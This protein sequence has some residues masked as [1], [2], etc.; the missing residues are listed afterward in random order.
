M[1]NSKNPAQ[2]APPGS[3][4]AAEPSFAIYIALWIAWAIGF[5]LT[6]FLILSTRGDNLPPG[7]G[8][9]QGCGIVLKSEYSRVLDISLTTWSAGYFLVAG[10]ILFM[11]RFS[12]QISLAPPLSMLLPVTSAVGVAAGI[13]SIVIMGTVLGEFCYYCVALH[14]VNLLFFILSLLYASQDWCH[15]QYRRWKAN[16]PTLPFSPI[17]LHVVLALLFIGGQTALMSLAHSGPP[18][19]LVEI[20]LKT[21]L[22]VKSIDD[23]LDVMALERVPDGGEIVWT[24]KGPRDAPYKIVT[25]TCPTCPHCKSAND[26]LKAIMAQ[27]PGQL[28]V[29][30]RFFPLWKCNDMMRGAKLSEDHKDACK[31]VR[32]ATAVAIADPEVFETYVN[33]LYDNQEEMTAEKASDKA[34][35]VVGRDE[36]EKAMTSDTLTRRERQDGDLAKSFVLTGVPHVFMAGGQV[37]GGMSYRSI[38]KLFQ[39]EFGW[40][41]SGKEPPQDLRDEFVA[42]DSKTIKKIA[43]EGRLASRQGDF[44]TAAAKFRR[45]LDLQPHAWDV[46]IAYSELLAT[47]GDDELYDPVAASKTIAPAQELLEKKEVLVKELPAKTKQE[48]KQKAELIK[49]LAGIWAKY[50]EVQA[51]VHAANGDFDAARESL[52]NAIRHFQRQKDTVNVNRL[53]R[54]MQ[55]HYAR[56]M[57]PPRSNM[58]NRGRRDTNRPYR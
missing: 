6:I 9:N 38:D 14:G 47:S 54:L 16:V 36:F 33:W 53:E 26:V 37:Y 35:E 23:V 10:L 45:A 41:P 25:F 13:W 2:D 30:M 58:R 28:R 51:A 57:A 19:T 49:K 3:S 1:S 44:R 50:H 17:A 43:D 20:D 39:K 4:R 7:C 40:K 52:M 27:Y 55:D 5:G 56:N 24:S 8:V 48:Q 21:V 34:R 11:A 42:L 46:R 18:S 29:D 22:G 15:R 12:F 32:Y 31:L